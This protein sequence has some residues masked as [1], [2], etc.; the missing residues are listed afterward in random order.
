MPVPGRNRALPGTAVRDGAGLAGTGT[1]D[2]ANGPTQR[3]G[4]LALFG[5]ESGEQ[6]VGGGHGL[7]WVGMAMFEC[8]IHPIGSHRHH[9]SNIH[10]VFHT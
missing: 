5:V 1:S 7:L 3:L 9:A 6:S 4:D 8:S 10:D 2:H